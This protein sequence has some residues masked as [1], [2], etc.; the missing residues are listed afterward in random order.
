[1]KLVSIPNEKYD[2]YRVNVIFDCYKWDPQFLDNNKDYKLI[3]CPRLDCVT[4][5]GVKINNYR[6]DYCRRRYP[7]EFEGEGQFMALLERSNYDIEEKTHNFYAKGFSPVYKKDIELLRLTFKDVADIS[8]LD[9]YKRNDNY[10]AVPDCELD[11]EE[12]NVL[13]AGVLIGTL[14]KG[15][16]KI[17]HELYHSHPDIFYNH[18][19]LTE[20]Q[21]M[22]YLKGY[23]LD[24]ETNIK[25]ICVVNYL[26]I[27]LGGGKIANSKLKN[28]Y[29]KNLRNTN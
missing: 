8:Q 29:P 5:A 27:A 21:M 24:I 2:E 3:S 19:E 18:I 9:I 28:Y 22:D 13:T 17:A 20:S 23:E 15:I 14:N 4:S 1:M 6:T 25:G 7:H 12:I 26:G 10:Y 16:I 11:F